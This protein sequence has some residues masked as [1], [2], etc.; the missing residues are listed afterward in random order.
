MARE[1][2]TTVDRRH[3]M[4]ARPPCPRARPSALSP[5]ARLPAYV[6]IA[7]LG[8][9]L[10]IIAPVAALPRG[11]VAAVGVAAVFV[12]LQLGWTAAAARSEE[13][14]RTVEGLSLLAARWLSAVDHAAGGGT[15]EVVVPLDPATAA[16]FGVAHRLFLCASYAVHPVRDVRAVPSRPG[17]VVVEQPAAPL[18]DDLRGW[19]T[20]VRQCPK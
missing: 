13:D 12:A 15:D 5:D 17:L 1:A 9:S 16:L 2:V 10:A 18:G 6:G 19:R 20:V 4:W 11:N 14:F 8:A 3:G 7:A